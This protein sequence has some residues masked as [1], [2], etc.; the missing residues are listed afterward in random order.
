MM[1]KEFGVTIKVKPRSPRN[2]SSSDRRSLRYDV[3]DVFDSAQHRGVTTTH[4]AHITW[5][6]H[7]TLATQC[8]SHNHHSFRSSLLSSLITNVSIFFPSHRRCWN[9]CCEFKR[10]SGLGLIVSLSSSCCRL[11]EIRCWRG[12]I[13]WKMKQFHRSSEPTSLLCRL[14]WIILKALFL[15]DSH[16]FKEIIME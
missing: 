14:K 11:S 3:P 13:A 7:A 6:T 12:G 10:L 15:E 2:F 5:A 8:N 4:T 16:I 9:S 1:Q